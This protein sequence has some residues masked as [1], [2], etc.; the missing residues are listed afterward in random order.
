VGLLK[1]RFA[2]FIAEGVACLTRDETRKPGKP[3]AGGGGHRSF[4]P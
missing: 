2:W 3:P 4:A 1:E